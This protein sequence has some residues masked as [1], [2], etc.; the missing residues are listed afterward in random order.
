MAEIIGMVD[1]HGTIFM[2]NKLLPEEYKTKFVEV[3]AELEDKECHAKRQF[4]KSHLH[5][6]EGVKNVYRAYI[7]KIS[8]WRIHVQYGPDKRI[9]LCEILAPSEHDRGTK[10]KVIKQKKDKYF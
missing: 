10:K 5:K 6:V 7:D 1:D 3:L 9:H 2:G 4:P 8:G